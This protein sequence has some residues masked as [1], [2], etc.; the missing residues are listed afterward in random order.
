MAQGTQ[1]KRVRA[2]TI[3]GALVQLRDVDPGVILH[4]PPSAAA[5]ALFLLGADAWPPRPR[6]AQPNLNPS[7]T[8]PIPTENK[9]SKRPRS[10]TLRMR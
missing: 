7:D 5:S 3:A 8:T 9:A 10:G 4:L 2:R 6:A 1:L